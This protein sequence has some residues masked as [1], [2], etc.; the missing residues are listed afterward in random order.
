E[1]EWG[2]VFT[3]EQIEAAL[4][5]HRPKLLAL[6]QGDTSTTMA[7]PLADIGQL[8]RKYDALFYVDATATLGGMPL[9]VDA[10][11]IDSVSAGLQ[12]CLG[13]PPGSAPV[14]LGERIVK[15]IERRRHIEQGLQ[16]PGY[17]PGPG[18]VIRS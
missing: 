11:A 2:T 16:P 3:P 5:E 10:W 7:Q 15:V 12:K 13:G 6:C 1:A 4:R 17:Q 14:T 9:P 18:P 8:C